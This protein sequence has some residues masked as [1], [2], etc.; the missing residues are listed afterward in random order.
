MSP[1]GKFRAACYTI[2]GINSFA[3]TFYLNYVYFYFRDRF[4][5]NDR[6]NLEL[7]ALIGVVCIFA[8]LG[9]GKFANRFSYFLTLKIGF[10]I[11]AA[12]LAIGA[13][14]NSLTMS[15]VATCGVMA[16]TSCIWPVLE[17]FVSRGPNPARSIGIYNLI[18]AATNA[19]AFF[20]G[21]TLI[22]KFGYQ[23]LFYLPLVLMILQF[24]SI[25]WLQGIQPKMAPV[26][27]VPDSS[28]SENR[29]RTAAQAK[30]FQRMAWLA[31]PL[32]Y[33]AINT[34]IAVLPG[35]AH[36]FDLSPMFAGFIC[37]LW[38]FVRGAAFIVLWQWT[39]WHYRFRW[40]VT[41][42]VLMVISF[43]VIL[44]APSLIVMLIAQLIF[45][46]TI[47]LMYYS[48]LFYAMDAHDSSSEQGG[49][50]E[51]SIGIGNCLGPATGAAAL[52]LAPLNPTAGA[53]SVT[54]LL[55]LGLGGLCWLRKPAPP[56]THPKE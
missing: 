51:A 3:V 10:I 31:N 38:C 34:L 6:Q 29:H 43:I 2:E 25:F 21:G 54:A 49:I 23:S 4:G 16:G 50:H 14:F 11:M 33:L 7:A 56:K 46:A 8:P 45:G 17:T 20:I 32:A 24:F 39:G 40:L 36:K 9:A 44:V 5:F 55:T 30:Q 13:H 12:G 18:W 35:I 28:P 26:A 22:E 48:S 19:I 52:W 27:A 37:S 1:A 47:G 53:W 41:A 15:T 42:Y